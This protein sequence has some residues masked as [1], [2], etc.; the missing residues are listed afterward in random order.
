LITVAAI[1]TMVGVGVHLRASSNTKTTYVERMAERNSEI[2]DA[3]E[4]ALQHISDDKSWVDTAQTGVAFPSIKHGSTIFSGTVTDANTDTTPTSST[5]NFILKLTAESG[6]FSTS[7]QLEIANTVDNATYSETLTGMGATFYWPLNE[8]KGT[9]VVSDQIWN[10][11]GTYLDPSVVAAATNDEGGVV[12]L[13]DDNDDQAQISY[14]PMFAE[15]KGSFS[16]WVKNSDLLAYGLL[17]MRYTAS[18]APNLMLG[19]INGGLYAFVSDDGTFSYSD[20]ANSSSGILEA[21]MWHHVVLTFGPSGLTVYMDG[22]RVARNTGNVS[23]LET[24][25]KRNGGSQPLNIG[26]AYIYSFLS[27]VKVGFTGSI[28]HVVYFGAKQLTADEVS[29]LASVKP[30]LPADISVVEDSWVRVYD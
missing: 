24:G 28:A 11:S 23:G 17:G 19:T 15:T 20:M 2:L 4:Y 10:S 14:T 9:A 18:G 1:V 30:D 12:P 27:V 5:T 29:K 3:T 6:S 13:F 8:S 21:E 25:Q 22:Q 7:A 16:L 26:A